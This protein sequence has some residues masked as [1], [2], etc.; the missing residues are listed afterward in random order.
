ML[1]DLIGALSREGLGAVLPTA[2]G[3]VVALLIAIDVHEFS[4]AWM[5]NAMGD[6][7]A[8]DLGRLTL[9][10]LAHLDPLGTLMLL[11][12]GFGWGKPVPVNPYRLRGNPR[13]A[14][15]AISLAGSAANLLTAAVFGL[16]LRIGYNTLSP[17]VWVPFLLIVQ[18]NVVLAIFNLLPI[19]PLDG[20]TVLLGVLPGEWAAGL[21]RYQ[22]YGPL[23]LL[24]LIFAGS[25]YGSNLLGAFIGPI[26]D[27][28]VRIFTG[29]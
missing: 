3:L 9:N 21:S 18:L 6:S 11:V 28:F 24:L 2:I 7:T 1:F 10:P 29:F 23:L 13:Q 22:A 20:F 14:S 8:R 4:H 27:F 12:A 19:P 16:P 26:I 25:F 17:Y 15:A 5:A